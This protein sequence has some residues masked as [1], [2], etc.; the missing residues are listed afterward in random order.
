M[1]S[2]WLSNVWRGWNQSHMVILVVRRSVQS[3]P[4]K[5]EIQGVNIPKPIPKCHRS[6]FP[7][8]VRFLKW[9]YPNSWKLSMEDPQQKIHG[10]ETSNSTMSRGEP[11]LCW[12][13]LASIHWALCSALAWQWKVG[14]KSLKRWSEMGILRNKEAGRSNEKG[15]LRKRNGDIC[16]SKRGDVTKVLTLNHFTSSYLP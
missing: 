10:L 15:C 12:A 1:I 3:D 9:G 14:Q 2:K 4:L 8:N 16:S 6:H 11:E 7:R 5:P 13:A